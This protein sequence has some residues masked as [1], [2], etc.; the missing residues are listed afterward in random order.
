MGIGSCGWEKKLLLLLVPSSTSSFEP[1]RPGEVGGISYPNKL[2]TGGD[3]G[4]VGRLS[5][6][7]A[8]V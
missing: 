8:G 2:C 4:V 3:M 6:C 5:S 1:L 7:A